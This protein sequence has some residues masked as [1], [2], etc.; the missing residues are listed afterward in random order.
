MSK[1][2]D[3]HLI[4]PAKS[5]IPYPDI[6]YSLP[7]GSTFATAMYIPAISSLQYYYYNVFSLECKTE[8]FAIND[9]V[10]FH[11]LTTPKVRSKFNIYRSWFFD[12][13]IDVYYFRTSDEAYIDM[14]LNND[15][16]M[17]KYPDIYQQLHSKYPEYF[18]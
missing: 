7:S 12:D 3:N 9:F 18:I 10:A 4:P 8:L 14:F 6:D 2:Y 11:K 1:R 16:A 17:Y 15:R 13:P 5:T